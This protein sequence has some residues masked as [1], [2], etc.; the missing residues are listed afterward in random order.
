[1]SLLLSGAKTMTFAGTEMQCLEIYSGEAYTINLQ[2]TDAVGSPIDATG[3]VL[4]PSA[5]FYS[6]DNVTY[7][8]LTDVVTLGAITL[9]PDPPPTPSGYANLDADWVD[10]LT[11]SGY[12]YIPEE[13]ANGSGSPVATPVPPLNDGTAQPTNTLVIVTIEISKPSSVGTLPNDIQRVPIG[14][15]V[16][17]Q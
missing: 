3:W 11:G 10:I 13:L 15:I 4:T 6:V 2:F 12:L 14:F 17:Y 5:K 8:G 7:D 1:M 9:T 16:R